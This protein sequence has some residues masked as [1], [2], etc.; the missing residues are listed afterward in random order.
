MNV[1]SVIA[2]EKDRTGHVGHHAEHHAAE[3][4]DRT[5]GLPRHSRK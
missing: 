3:E 1:D 5:E 2:A 4:K